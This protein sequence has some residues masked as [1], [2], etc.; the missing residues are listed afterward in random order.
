MQLPEIGEG[1]CILEGAVALMCF[2]SGYSSEVGPHR[3]PFRFTGRSIIHPF[4]FRVQRYY[5]YLIYA[6]ILA[7]K[8]QKY[9]VK[10]KKE[11]AKPPP[12]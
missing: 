4:R 1:N 7:K 11:G 6:S 3:C 9:V 12:S 2:S 5:N 10:H 8:L